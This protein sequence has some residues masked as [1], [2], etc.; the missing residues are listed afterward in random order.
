MI[1]INPTKMIVSG[2]LAKAK[3]FIGPAKSQMELLLNQ[4]SYQNLS[5]GVRRLWLD[6]DTYVQC[7]KCYYYQ[8]CRIWVRPSGEELQE[9]NNFILIITDRYGEEAFAWSLLENKQVEDESFIPLGKKTFLEIKKDLLRLN[10]I[11]DTKIKIEDYFPTQLETTDSL[12]E[13]WW[14]CTGTANC[15]AYTGAL[16]TIDVFNS[17]ITTWPDYFQIDLDKM[18][19]DDCVCDGNAKVSKLNYPVFY[20]GVSSGGQDPNFDFFNASETAPLH[21]RTISPIDPGSKD[22]PRFEWMIPYLSYFNPY[23]QEQE[24]WD[25][26]AYIVR[27]QGQYQWSSVPEDQKNPCNLSPAPEDIAS[28]ERSFNWFHSIFGFEMHMNEDD[29]SWIYATKNKFRY[30]IRF[31]L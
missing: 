28:V 16:E 19:N 20:I 30:Y 3:T 29:G 14:D 1:R 24:V 23:T 9:N 12:Y 6:K 8:E 18:N 2:N 17:A 26:T 21:R 25:K 5:Q 4:L 10:L 15:S 11:S 7:R 13:S 31:S 27:K 22:Q